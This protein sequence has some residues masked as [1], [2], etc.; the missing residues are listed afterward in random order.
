VNFLF[1]NRSDLRQMT[2]NFSLMSCEAFLIRPYSDFRFANGLP[3]ALL[4]GIGSRADT[5]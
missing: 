2:F 3:I 4:A 5:T 1:T